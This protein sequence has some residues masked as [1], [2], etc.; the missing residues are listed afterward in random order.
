MRS[1]WLYVR[2]VKNVVQ[3]Q[4]NVLKIILLLDKFIKAGISSSTASF[5]V[6]IKGL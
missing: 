1:T 4:E 3:L 5:E 6:V 2:A